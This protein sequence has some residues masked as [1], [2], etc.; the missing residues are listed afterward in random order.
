MSCSASRRANFI[1]EVVQ[2]PRVWSF[3]EGVRQRSQS[4]RCRNCGAKRLLPKSALATRNAYCTKERRDGISGI[5]T[6]MPE[7]R[8]A[9]TTVRKWNLFKKTYLSRIPT[10]LGWKLP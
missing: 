8:K 7:F 3:H 2:V 10:N 6:K 1:K 9:L 4:D 5:L